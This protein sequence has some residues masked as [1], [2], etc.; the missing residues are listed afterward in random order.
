[1]LPCLSED[2]EEVDGDG[3]GGLGKTLSVGVMPGLPRPEELELLERCGPWPCPITG[4]GRTGLT[5][6]G[7]RG[8]LGLRADRAGLKVVMVSE[9]ELLLVRRCAASGSLITMVCR[10]LPGGSWAPPGCLSGSNVSKTTSG[11]CLATF[12]RSSSR[13]SWRAVFMVF[14]MS[15]QNGQKT[16]YNQ[17]WSNYNQTCMPLTQSIELPPVFV[18]FKVHSILTLTSASASAS[19]VLWSPKLA[20][21]VVLGED[22]WEWLSM[23]AFLSGWLIHPALPKVVRRRFSGL[24]VGPLVTATLCGL[25]GRGITLGGWS[26]LRLG[27]WLSAPFLWRGPAAPSDR[28]LTL[29]KKKSQFDTLSFFFF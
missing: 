29:K 13:S 9:E 28:T 3:E 22:R 19:R 20:C 25:Q 11:A 14:S 24:S 7:L 1:M 18:Y 26:A 2:E 21:R 8:A 12:C 6:G 5:G 15:W 4:A 10:G 17:A 27:L 16:K 23:K